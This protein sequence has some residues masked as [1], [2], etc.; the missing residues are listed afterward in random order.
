MKKLLLTFAISLVFSI[1]SYAQSINVGGVDIN[2]IEG[3]QYIKISTFEKGFSS[4]IYIEVDYGQQVCVGG[5]GS[6][7]EDEDGK[8]MIFNSTI[9]VCNLF[10]EL[11]WQYIDSDFYFMEHTTIRINTFIFKRSNE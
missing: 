1:T 7:F 5:L 2:Q 10:S 8:D 9:H 4:K 3:L 11:G 6:R